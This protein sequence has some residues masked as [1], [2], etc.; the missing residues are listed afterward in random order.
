MVFV[1]YGKV[2]AGVDFSEMSVD[3]L[4]V[5]DAKTVRVHLPEAVL[6]DDLPAL[7]NER[8]F[9]ADRDTG[10]LTRADPKLETEVRRVAEGTIKEVALQSGVVDRAD[11]NAQNY[12]LNFLQGLGFD[13]VE[14]YDVTPPTPPPF[15]QEV[16]KGFVVTPAAP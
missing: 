12:M 10:L 4:Q 14:F 1:A 5:V 16:P 9:V 15:E 2:V 7:D 11:F 13:N 3:D 8:S 6:F